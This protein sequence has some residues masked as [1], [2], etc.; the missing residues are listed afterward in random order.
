MAQNGTLSRGVPSS[1]GSSVGAGHLGCLPLPGPG[2]CRW[3]AR[4]TSPILRCTIALRH[5]MPNG[6]SAAAPLPGGGG[7]RSGRVADV[8][9]TPV[10]VTMPQTRGSGQGPRCTK[11]LAFL[12]RGKTHDLR[13]YPHLPGR[14]RRPGR[15]APRNPSPGPGR[16]RRAH[17]ARVGLLA[18]VDVV[19]RT[20]PALVGCL[21]SD[22]IVGVGGSVRLGVL[23]SIR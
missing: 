23:L 7:W 18:H 14:R 11:T 17:V 2:Q 5:R 4:S 22:G 20:D 13:L 6:V 9:E 1:A 16:C 3:F 12:G 21:R 10:F 8:T 15:H 19:D